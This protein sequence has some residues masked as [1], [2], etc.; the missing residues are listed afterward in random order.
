M[1]LPKVPLAAVLALFLAAVVVPLPANALPEDGVSIGEGQRKVIAYDGMG[2]GFSTENETAQPDLC[3]ALPTCRVIP[4]E[5]VLPDD[6]DAATNDFA[7]QVRLDWETSQLPNN[8]GQANDLDLFVWDEPQGDDPLARSVGTQVP[9][10]VGLGQP[11]KGKYNIVVRNSLGNNVGF[12]LTFRWID[13]RLVVP[14][15]SQEPSFTPFF[16]SGEAFQDGPTPP[17][18]DGGFAGS[19]FIPTRPA[20]SRVPV[21][22]SL[23]S[24]AFPSIVPTAPDELASSSL[25]VDEF[26]VG[27]P[28]DIRALLGAGADDPEGG[29]ALFASPV[30]ATGPLDPP[31]SA[32]LWFWFGV[33]PLVL[34]VGLTLF[35]IRRRP[36]VLSFRVPTPAGTA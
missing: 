24:G 4:L 26:V 8:Q 32:L 31:S 3:E 23:S 9:E 35:M 10:I 21:G 7:V 29:L 18:P 25:E 11:Q 36:A 30:A 12:K 2:L 34:L 20:P 16:E 6:F 22:S 28:D 17:A 33:A 19:S 13:G 14:D 15:E 5:V 1:R 27:G